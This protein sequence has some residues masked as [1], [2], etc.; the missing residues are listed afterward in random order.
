MV[1]TSKPR[2][3]TDYVSRFPPETQKIL[4][5]IRKSI[6]ESVPDADEVISYG[7]PCFNW[8][9]HYLIYFAGFKKHVS[10]YP[11]PRGNESFKKLLSPYKGGKGTVQFPLDEPIPFDLI[12]KIV[13]FRMK[14]N[15]EREV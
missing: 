15:K 13:K 11:A 12:T 4:K 6:R 2:D 9:G 7:I 1:N 5:Q 14:V 10:G 8:K 3:F